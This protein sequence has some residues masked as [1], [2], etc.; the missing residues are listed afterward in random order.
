MD[1][2]RH[3]LLAGAGLAADQD[4][5]VGR[6]DARDEVAHPLCGRRSADEV[7]V[8]EALLEGLGTA[9]QLIARVGADPRGT[10][11]VREASGGEAVGLLPRTTLTVDPQHGDDLVGAPVHRRRDQRAAPDSAVTT[12]R[13][14]I[15]LSISSCGILQLRA[16]VRT[17]RRGDRRGTFAGGEHE[18]TMCFERRPR[19]IT[20]RTRD[21]IAPRSGFH[22]QAIAELCNRGEVT[23]RAIVATGECEQL[24]ARHLHRHVTR[25]LRE[26]HAVDRQEREPRRTDHELVTCLEAMLADLC[27]VDQRA[28]AGDERQRAIA[29]LDHAVM[30]RH[31]WIAE[32]DEAVLVAPDLAAAHRKLEFPAR[33]RAFDDD[34]SRQRHAGILV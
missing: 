3:Q 4:R 23:A 16:L 27:A 24:A 10:G 13:W 6:A 28:L 11:E 9:R 20:G 19:C 25:R 31:R 8:G 2:A 29:Q 18:C 34:E 17:D 7:A 21:R 26:R 22:A 14:L 32:V 5:R 15:T 12:W 30:A 1:R 33:V